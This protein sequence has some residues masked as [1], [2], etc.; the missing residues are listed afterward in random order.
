MSHYPFNRIITLVSS[1]GDITL[2]G[3][4][5]LEKQDTTAADAK[6]R[7]E[8]TLTSSEHNPSYLLRYPLYDLSVRVFSFLLK[9]K[10]RSYQNIGRAAQVLREAIW[11]DWDELST[12]ADSRTDYFTGSQAE[13][14]GP[15]S[16]RMWAIYSDPS[17]FFDGVPEDWL[18]EPVWKVT[19]PWIWAEIYGILALWTIDE[20]VVYLNLGNPYKAA[21]WMLRASENVSWMMFLSESEQSPEQYRREFASSGGRGK[22]NKYQP[23]KDHVLT[24]AKG[25]NYPSRRNAALSMKDAVLIKARELGIPLSPD[26]ACKTI[27]GWLIRAGWFPKNK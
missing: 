26:Q 4:T 10:G 9:D 25:K 12:E 15:T 8:S 20:A 3:L 11:S 16:Y 17:G 7:G 21:I 6:L 19:E 18:D 5:I 1:S 23:L 22:K 13:K 27:E 14:V 24:L 2:S